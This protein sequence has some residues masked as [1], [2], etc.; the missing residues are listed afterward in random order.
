MFV[1]LPGGD[2]AMVCKQMWE[3]IKP[4]FC[5]DHP[6]S[7]TFISE[8]ILFILSHTWFTFGDKAYSVCGGTAM[9]QRHSVVL[10]NIFMSHFFAEFFEQHPHWKA[11]LPFFK[12]FLDDIFGFW[13]GS[14]LLFQRFVAQINRWSHDKGWKIE[15]ELEQCQ[16]GGVVSFLDLDIYKNSAGQWHTKLFCKTSDVHA[17]LLPTSQHPPH[18]C[19]HIPFAVAHRVR[20]ACSED[21]AFHE[22]RDLFINV[23]FPKRG[24]SKK[25]VKKCF[26]R[27]G[28]TPYEVLLRGVPH[29][30]P[31]EDFTPFVYP[32]EVRRDL[33]KHLVNASQSAIAQLLHA[34]LAVNLPQKTMY[35]VQANVKRF[36]DR[37]SVSHA[38]RLKHGCFQCDDPGC[39]L[40]EVLEVGDKITS[41]SVGTAIG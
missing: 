16:F 40:H 24:Y 18:I 5:P 41:T 17:Y 3:R 26:F 34:P 31:D 6:V 4:R 36:V 14:W 35:K 8:L 28:E 20:R 32:F 11:H 38:P 37:A 10:A 15:F 33:N 21:S 29:T 30:R 23:L 39:R 22:M 25:A 2:C 1:N 9:G 12:R 27:V 19:K 13:K 7:G